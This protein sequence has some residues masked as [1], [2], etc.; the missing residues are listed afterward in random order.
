MLDDRT[1]RLLWLR[2]G[3]I[4]GAHRWTSSYGEDATRGAGR[5]WAKALGGLTPQHLALGIEA[6]ITRGEDWPPPL[7]EFR[8]MCLGVPSL[9]ECS[10]LIRAQIPTPF[11]RLAWQNLDAFRFRRA[12][13]RE[14]DRL[15]RDAYNLARDHVLQGGQ[16][17]PEPSGEI[18]QEQHEVKPAAPSTVAAA[19]AEIDA[20]LGVE[21]AM[22][23]P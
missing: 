9:A 2:M 23:E 12:D 20:A 22:G 13:A 19:L 6:C 14:A 18:T 16:L 5:T 4:F 15:I 11:T 1:M 8:A 7:P 17:P 10:A 21:R 3:E